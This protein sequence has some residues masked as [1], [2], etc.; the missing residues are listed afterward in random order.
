[1]SCTTGEYILIIIYLPCRVKPPVAGVEVGSIAMQTIVA[2]YS[3]LGISKEIGLFQ[4]WV[5]IIKADHCQTLLNQLH[6]F[7]VVCI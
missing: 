6:I 5:G 7:L 1:M 4:V 2:C 3:A